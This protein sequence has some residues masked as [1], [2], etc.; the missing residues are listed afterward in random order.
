MTDWTELAKWVNRLERSY[1]ITL[2]ALGDMLTLRD[3][4]TG[5][6]SKRVAAFTIGIARAMGVPSDEIR[7]LSRGAFLHDIGKMATPDSILRK[8]GALTPA[9]TAIIRD[10]CR[11][12]YELVRRIPFLTGEAEIVYAHQEHYDGM[13]YPRGLKGEQIPLG[14]RL[15]AIANTLDTITSDR[16]YHAAQTLAAARGEIQTWSGHQFDPEM[17]RIFISMPAEIWMDLSREI[18]PQQHMISND[19]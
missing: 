11:C 5:E 17:V 15:V 16:P 6:H 3:T 9:E 13:G 2:Q 4:E 12:G 7:A 10:H 14:A 19:N 18:D 1:D 8:R